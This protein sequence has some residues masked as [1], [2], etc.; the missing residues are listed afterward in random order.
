MQPKRLAK[1]AAFSHLRRAN[2][3]ASG[4]HVRSYHIVNVALHAACSALVAAIAQS[5]VGM[6]PLPAGL[7]AVLFAAHP[8]HTEAVSH[9]LFVET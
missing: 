7:A 5:A 2:F 3:L 9:G 6:Q 4:L 1:A 8:V